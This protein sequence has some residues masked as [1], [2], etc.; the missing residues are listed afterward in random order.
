MKG[1]S[2]IVPA[3]NEEKGISATVTHLH[4]VMNMADI[5]YEIIVID[6]GSSDNTA[7]IGRSL[8]NIRFMANKRNMG[9]GYSIKKAGNSAQFDLIAITDA[10]GTY[11]NERIPDLLSLLGDDVEMVVGWRKGQDAKIPLTRRPVK[12]IIRKFAEFVAGYPI[13]DPNSGLRIFRRETLKRNAHLLPSGFSLTTTITLIIAS[14]GGDIV[15]EPIKYHQ[16]TGISKFHPIKDTWGMISLI[17]RSTLLFTP[18]RVFV[19]LALAL[20]TLSLIILVYSLYWL[21]R[22]PD[23]TISILT[24]T[25]IQILCLGLL[26]DLVNRQNQR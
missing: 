14:G 6:D 9:Y 5:S 17:V 3:Y 7:K 24:A 13:P 4:T 23:G 19:P 26:A 22:I 10:D 8:P 21:E 2:I 18:L 11:P 1:I 15:Y 16:R 25:G 12:W 20:F